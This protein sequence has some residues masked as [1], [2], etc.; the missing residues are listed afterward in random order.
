MRERREH[1]CASLPDPSEIRMIRAVV[2]AA[3]LI[4]PPAWAGTNS[5][6]FFNAIPTL[7]EVG[8]G[9][10]IALVAGAAGWVIRRR[11]RR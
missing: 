4:A 2:I 5:M 3:A 11:N 1:T 8:L 9:A 10:L 6:I 7:D